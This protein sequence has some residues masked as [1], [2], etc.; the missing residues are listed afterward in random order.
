MASEAE[1]VKPED[2]KK[3]IRKDGIRLFGYSMPW[4]VVLVIVML[5][6][7]L[8]Y[9]KG[10]L[11]GM[12]NDAPAQKVISAGPAVNVGSPA[13]VSEI[14]ELINKFSSGKYSKKW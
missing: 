2:E 3:I 5:A 11:A 9:N 6:L 7:Y 8:A 12:M 4:T 1:Q 14:E 13:E 10:M